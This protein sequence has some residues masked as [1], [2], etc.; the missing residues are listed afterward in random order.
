MKHFGIVVAAGTGSRFG[1]S[2]PKQ[3]YSIDGKTILEHSIESLLALE[4]LN[5]LVVVL[6]PHDQYWSTLNI[7]HHPKILTTIGGEKRSDSSL[8]GLKALEGLATAE[9]FVLVHDA[10]RPFVAFEDLTKLI[11]QTQHHPVG[12][13]LAAKVVDTIKS[14]LDEAHIEKTVDRNLLYRA[15]TPQ[16]FR[17]QKL[18]DALKHV[19]TKNL[20]ISD[21]SMALELQGFHP[22]LVLTNVNTN[23]ITFSGDLRT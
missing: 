12:G 21:D 7:C 14:S 2:K 5:Q 19:Q 16:C 11:A 3:Y 13:I 10:A 23:K 1:G 22:L 4:K 17:Y 6:H 8:N 20:S 18:L 9:D 15:L